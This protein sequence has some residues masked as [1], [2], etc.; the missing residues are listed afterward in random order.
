MSTSKVALTQTNAEVA[1]TTTAGQTISASPTTTTPAVET[2]PLDP[3]H[4]KLTTVF[5]KENLNENPAEAVVTFIDEYCLE[6]A[7]FLNSK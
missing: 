7:A 2:A 5:S 3:C 1:S 4:Q 6:T